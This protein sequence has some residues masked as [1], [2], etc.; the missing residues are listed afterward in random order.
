LKKINGNGE[1]VVI[2]WGLLLRIMISV[3][4]ARLYLRTLKRLN[5]RKKRK[6]N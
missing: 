1:K 6:R 2:R 3:K 5:K 4:E